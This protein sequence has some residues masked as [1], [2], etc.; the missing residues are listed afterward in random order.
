MFDSSDSPQVIDQGTITG[1]LLHND[2]LSDGSNM[3]NFSTGLRVHIT[4][5]MMATNV[6]CSSS[7]GSSSHI[8]IAM[9]PGMHTSIQF[10]I[11]RDKERG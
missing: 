11:M 1:I 10:T 7:D 5:S 4:Q 3:R 9:P 8:V 2:P 6:S